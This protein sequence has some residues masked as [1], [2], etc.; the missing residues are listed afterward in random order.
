[1]KAK[2][3]DTNNWSL[4][5]LRAVRDDPKG[6]HDFLKK[7]SNEIDSRQ[8]EAYYEL[9]SSYKELKGIER[10]AAHL[11]LTKC[12][13]NGLIRFNK[14]GEWNVS[15]GIRCD[16]T[17]KGYKRL[18]D[19][20][21]L[22][23]LEHFS[24]ALQG[25]EISQCDFQEHI[26]ELRSDSVVYVDPPY[27]QS[28]GSVGVY[29]GAWNEVED[30]RLFSCLERLRSRGGAFV[31]SNTISYRGVENERLKKWIQDNKLWSEEREYSYTV[32]GPRGAKA[33][34][35]LVAG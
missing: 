31:M 25:V 18:E 8:K 22:E 34:E 27:I 35:V 28:G 26:D 2:L 13:F 15:F 21:S 14:R 19:M 29:D 11:V 4:E 9:R 16:K 30:E 1:L 23:T 17:K 33:V 7:W 10:G 20:V 12:G 32:G 5:I 24:K 3:S 6:V